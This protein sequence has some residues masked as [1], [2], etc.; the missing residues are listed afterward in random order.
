M[1]WNKFN[2]L[3]FNR[4][5]WPCSRVHVYGDKLIGYPTCA[6]V[7]HLVDYPS[8]KQK[9][10]FAS[11]GGATIFFQNLLHLSPYTCIGYNYIYENLKNLK[12]TPGRYLYLPTIMQLRNIVKGITMKYWIMFWLYSVQL[13]LH[14]WLYFVGLQK[15]VVSKEDALIQCTTC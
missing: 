5:S 7:A 4:V 13:L 2:H 8:C 1:C 15:K 3:S 10:L 14:V 11:P 9:A 12:K 6:L